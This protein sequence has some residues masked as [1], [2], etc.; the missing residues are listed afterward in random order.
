MT[1]FDDRERGFEAKFAHDQEARF[2]AEARRNRLLGL[3]AAERLGLSGPESL[4]YA[5]ALVRLETEAP[6]EGPLFARL[7]SDL[8][9][10]ASPALIRRRIAECLAEAQAQLARE[11]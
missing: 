10:R 7:A 3:W 1:T 2:R 4:A 8:G 5:G 11:G 6:G 9:E